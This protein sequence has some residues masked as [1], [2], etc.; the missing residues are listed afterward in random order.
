[1]RSR[2]ERIAVR[3]ITAPLMMLAL[4]APVT[5]AE[6]DKTADKKLSQQEESTM[7]GSGTE[8]EPTE[9]SAATSEQDFVPKQEISED[10]PIA[11]PAD[12]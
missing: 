5:A 1:M 11:L 7:V 4:F 3:Y 12:I 9:L 10:Y 8:Q 2:R 6:A